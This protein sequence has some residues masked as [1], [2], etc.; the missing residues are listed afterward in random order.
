LV[1]DHSGIGPDG[2]TPS[3]NSTFVENVNVSPTRIWS[4]DGVMDA[5]STGASVDI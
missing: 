4:I 2:G 5:D 3:P 1:L